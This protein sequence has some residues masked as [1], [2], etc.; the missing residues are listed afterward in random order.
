MFLAPVVGIIWKVSSIVHQV[1][2]NRKDID[3]LGNKVN[4]IV[5]DLKKEQM[6]ITDKM[7]TISNNITELLVSLHHLQQNME[8][9]KS[10]VKELSKP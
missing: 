8:E 7:N 1:N 5:V 6:T 3:G 9:I 4:T 10:D 2:D